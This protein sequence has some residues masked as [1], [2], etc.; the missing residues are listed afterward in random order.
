MDCKFQI[1]QL[2]SQV[3]NIFATLDQTNP[4]HTKRCI[5]H[6]LFNFLLGDSNSAEEFNVIKNNM[7]ILKENQDILSRT[8][9]R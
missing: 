9:F 8:S 6:S 4:K 2:T 7:T 1:T 3:N 5:I